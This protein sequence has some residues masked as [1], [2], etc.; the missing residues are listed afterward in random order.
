MKYAF[1]CTNYN[2]SHFTEGAV[3]TLLAN[4]IRP[5]RI[6]VVDNASGL[7]E[8]KAL[9]RLAEKH[10][11][12]EVIFNRDNIG[13]SAGLNIGIRR[14]SETCGD[15][16][17]LVIGNNDL[18]FPAD[19]SEKLHSRLDELEEH[20]VVCPDILTIDGVRQNPHAIRPVSRLRE[21]VFDLY[22]SSYLLGSAISSVARLTFPLTR[23]RDNDQHERAGYI[24]IGLGACYILSRKFMEEISEIPSHTFLLYEEFFLA[25]CLAERGQAFYYDPNIMVIHHDH[26]SVKSVGSRTMWSHGKQS[27]RKYRQYIRPFGRN[28]ILPVL[29]GLQ[30]A[31]N[32]PK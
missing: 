15:L 31:Q 4:S 17:L 27:H 30:S 26:G 3:E 22:Y 6:I 11:E 16:D 14:A 5:Q 32:T 21:V 18:E 8:Q 20:F 24:Y 25:H 23:R 29:D 7:D 2:N 13:Y 10:A 1:V 28:P 12:V 19:F 9:H